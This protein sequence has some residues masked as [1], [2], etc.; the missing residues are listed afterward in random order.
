[1]WASVEG[2][3]FSAR[4][5][6]KSRETLVDELVYDN[7][8]SLGEYYYEVLPAKQKAEAET[9]EG[10]EPKRRKEKEEE[11]NKDVDCVV[12][13]ETKADTRVKPCLHVVVC[14]ACSDKLKDSPN[15]RLCVFC[16]QPIES[17]EDVL[18]T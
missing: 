8:W 2:K 7:G 3:A 18:K 6:Q 12:C 17:I 9:E 5:R 15:A 16:R 1:M 13:M 4:V 10:P 14:R 11:E